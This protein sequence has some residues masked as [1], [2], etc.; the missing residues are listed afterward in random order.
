MTL[1]SA[2]PPDTQAFPAAPAYGRAGRSIAMALLALL[3]ACTGPML[4]FDTQTPPLVLTTISHAGI[5]DGRARF[6][7]I[8]CTVLARV[9]EDCERRLWRVAEEPPAPS[10]PVSSGPLIHRWRILL[11]TGFGA[12]CFAHRVRAFE[13]AEERLGALGAELVH[14]PVTAFGSVMQNAAIVRDAITAERGNA[15]LLLLG[16]SKGAADAMAAIV[17]FDEAA[18]R[19]SAFAAIGGAVNGSP[20]AEVVPDWLEELIALMPGTDCD[21]GDRQALE[22]LAPRHRLKAVEA[23][24]A[25]L[26]VP[27]FS[28]VAFANEP[29]ISEILKPFWARLAAADPRNDGQMLWYDQILP[30]STLL[31]YLRGDHLAVAVPV[32]E[33]L[34]WLAKDRVDRN[35]FPRAAL[36][37]AVLRYL[38]EALPDPSRGGSAAA[39]GNGPST[40]MPQRP[41]AKPDPPSSL[42]AG[43]CE[44]R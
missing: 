34:P 8:F 33:K 38:D 20:L 1:G 14:V 7:E 25:G 12:Q 17:H 30:Q 32:A 4:P 16:Y 11:V 24:S 27:T 2:L 22:D 10:K 36:L 23:A 21:M 26:P 40:A 41:L 31:G 28:L 44:P 35:D 39:P 18:R 37:E 3:A 13:D 43:M 6:R 9:R 15:R 19:V 29:E 42:L 5:V